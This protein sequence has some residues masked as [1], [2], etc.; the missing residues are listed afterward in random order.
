MI[1]LFEEINN[2]IEDQGRDLK[3]KIKDKIFPINFESSPSISYDYLLLNSSD[4]YSFLSSEMNNI[5]SEEYPNLSDSQIYFIK[6]N[7]ICKKYFSD[8][9]DNRLLFKTISPNKKLKDIAN[10]I[11]SQRL[12]PE[13]IPQF[14]EIILYTNIN[15]DKAPRVFGFIGNVSIIYVLFYDPFHKI[16]D[17]IGKI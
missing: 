17:K 8:L 16:F 11:F 5:T 10:F 2:F 9:E 15:G 6:I 4:E 13:Q 14:I 12:E 7:E 3:Y 1:T